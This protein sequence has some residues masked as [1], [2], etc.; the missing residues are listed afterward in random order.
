MP[1]P[2]HLILNAMEWICMHYHMA[3]DWYAADLNHQLT[4]SMNGLVD[5][6][7]R[8]EVES[9]GSINTHDHCSNGCID[10]YSYHT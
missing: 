3:W 4:H 9:M 8:M 6:A 2:L 10:S 5:T 1:S 7:S